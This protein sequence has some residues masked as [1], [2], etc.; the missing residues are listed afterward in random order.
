MQG[1]ADARPYPLWRMAANLSASG[2]G[3]YDAGAYAACLN[4]TKKE[5]WVLHLTVFKNNWKPNDTE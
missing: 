3:G 4:M 1:D 5:F 2:M